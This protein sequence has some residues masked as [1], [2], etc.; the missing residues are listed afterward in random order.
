MDIYCMDTSSFIEM[1]ESYPKD[2]FPKLWENI[3][4]LCEEVRLIAPVEVKKRN[5][6]R[7]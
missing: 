4:K 1:K 5:R 7:R 6:T 2:I 3:D